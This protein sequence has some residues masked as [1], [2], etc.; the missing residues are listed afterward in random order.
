[1]ETS[2][3]IAELATALTKAQAVMEGAKK[4]GNNPHFRSSYP[5]L[6]SVWDAVR[7]PFAANGLSVVQGC[8]TSG[9][10]VTVCTLLLHTSGQW[11]REVL[12]MTANDHKP[13]SV[14]SAISYARRYQLAAMAGVAP[15]DDDGE[16]AEGRNKPKPAYT[17]EAPQ[18]RSAE[19]PAASSGTRHDA[20]GGGGE[21]PATP[22]LIRKVDIGSGAA[23]GF[24][25]FTWQQVGTDGFP[26]YNMTHFH[27]AMDCC[28]LA[29]PV[30]AE[31]TESA[32]K[33]F[34]IKSLTRAEKPG[35][36]QPMLTADQVPF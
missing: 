24:V 9:A 29:I 8:A 6:A 4:D 2:E 30:V 20:A 34:Y 12:T 7:E 14:G 22:W 18:A 19:S 11:I 13:Q 21:P 5:T 28:Q 36:A 1:M 17:V 32:N 33:K 27:L 10:D 35:E 26:V 23:K 15:E 25:H 31:I 16:A 3:Q